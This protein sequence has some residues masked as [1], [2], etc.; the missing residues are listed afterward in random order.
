M[1]IRFPLFVFLLALSCYFSGSALAQTGDVL[2]SSKIAI[3]TANSKEL[4]R[5]FNDIIELGFKGEEKASYSK[6]QAEF[7]LKDFFKKY[8]PVDFQFVHQ[9]TSNHGMKYAIGKYN[10]SGGS[11][12]VI[13][14]VKQF[15]GSDM[16]DSIVFEE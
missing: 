12:R 4:S 6:T 5:Y 8:S 7:V 9:G 11:F 13:V 3:K 15:K 10:Y 14:V 16:I 2:E 1:K